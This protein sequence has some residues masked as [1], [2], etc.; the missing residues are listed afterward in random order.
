MA[1]TNEPTSSEREYLW[2]TDHTNRLIEL[3]DGRIQDL[4][5]HTDTHQ[6]VL[7]YLFLWHL[8]PQV[9]KANGLTGHY[10]LE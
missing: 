6:A 3:A 1:A 4:P 2:L 8:Y 5:M 9:I 10:P 7:Q